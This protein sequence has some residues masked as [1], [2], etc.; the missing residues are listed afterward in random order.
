M[1]EDIQSRAR[2]ISYVILNSSYQVVAEYGDSVDSS[3]LLNAHDVELLDN[4]TAILQVMSR[5]YETEGD[6][7]IVEAVLQEL[8]LEDN[9]V[10]FEWRSLEHVHHADTC[11]SMQNQ[12]YL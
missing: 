3:I 4:D 11:I 5:T 10:V 9:E 1:Q 2:R 7:R 12:D 6:G 8:N